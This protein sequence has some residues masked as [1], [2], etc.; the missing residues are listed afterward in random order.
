MRSTTTKQCVNEKAVAAFSLSIRSNKEGQR[1]SNGKKAV[2]LREKTKPALA[3]I[4][5]ITRTR[6]A[7]DKLAD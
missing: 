1:T 3:C 5:L 7:R 4:T 6:R 2:Q